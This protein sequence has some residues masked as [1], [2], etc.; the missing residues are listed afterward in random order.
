MFPYTSCSKEQ[1]RTNCCTNCSA[2]QILM[3]TWAHHTE[4]CTKSLKVRSISIHSGRPKIL[5]LS[6]QQ[7]NEIYSLKTNFTLGFRTF[8]NV[9]EFLFKVR[10]CETD[11]VTVCSEEHDFPK[12]NGIL[13]AIELER[14][15]RII[16]LNFNDE[17]KRV[18]DLYDLATHYLTL[19]KLEFLLENYWRIRR[20]KFH[21]LCLRYSYWLVLFQNLGPPCFSYYGLSVHI[22]AST[23]NITRLS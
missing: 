18:L 20:S 14:L 1:S 10:V 2:K 7:S 21:H 12:A 8:P 11:R 4:S 16:L 6:K 23:W 19:E 3:W 9:A 15:D 17:T 22:G 13:K 5:F